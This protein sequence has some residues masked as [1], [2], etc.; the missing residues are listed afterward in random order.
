MAP[1]QVPATAAD[2]AALPGDPRAEVIGGEITEKASPSAEHGDAQLALGAMLRDG[3][4]RPAGGG[5]L[6][7]WWLMAE[8]EIELERHEVYLPDLVGWRRDRVPVRPSGRPVRD[9]PDWVC[10]ILSP[11]NAD[12]DLVDKLRTYKQNRIPHYWLVD[13]MARTLLVYRWTDGGYLAVCTARLGETVHA[14]PFEAVA[15]SLG[16]ET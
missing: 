5:P 16:V 4:H 15:L 9:R 3:F 2:L 6:G 8:V 7:G 12:R 11:S 10:E 13:P 14:E 1:R